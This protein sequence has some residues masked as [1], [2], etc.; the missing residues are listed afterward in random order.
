MPVHKNRQGRAW[1]HWFAADDTPQERR[2]LLKLDLLIIPYAFLGF[3]INYIDSSN[4]SERPAYEL[5]AQTPTDL[6]S[7]NA[8]VAGLA[9]DLNFHGNELINM[10]T[11][12]QVG[13]VL[14]QVPLVYLFPLVPMNWLIP[15][16]EVFWGVFT[17]LQ[18]RAQSYAEL[19]A[20]RFFI[21]LFE[22]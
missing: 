20:Y 7:D 4:I 22:V 16:V 18:Y 6:C 3:W 15:G 8:W 9:E 12:Y 19:M 2:L 21:G 13:S 5:F 14:G 1:Y 11:I 10:Q 17:L